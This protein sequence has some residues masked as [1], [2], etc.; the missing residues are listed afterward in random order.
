MPVVEDI[1]RQEPCK[2]MG[3]T[4][5]W[6]MLAN[7][8]MCQLIMMLESSVHGWEAWSLLLQYDLQ[9]TKSLWLVGGMHFFRQLE[10]LHVL[11]EFNFGE[12]RQTAV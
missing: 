5:V 4:M 10:P 1:I 9:S 3:G 12:G 6:K 11:I 7:S 2:N 8:F